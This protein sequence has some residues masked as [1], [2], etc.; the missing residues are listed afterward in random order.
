M[1]PRDPDETIIALF[2]NHAVQNEMASA[3]AGRP[4]FDDLEVVE[5]RFPG[6]RSVSVFPA[7]AVSHWATDFQTGY[8][9]Q[10]TYAERFSHQYRQFKQ[11]AA[12]TKSGTPLDYAPFLTE[13]RKAEL[14]AQNLYTIEQLA[15]IEGAELKNLGNGG[16]EMK[17]QAIAFIEESKVHAPDTQM[18]AELEALRARNAILEEDA[19][20]AKAAAVA[21]VGEFEAMSLDQL[22]QYIAT[23]SG[24]APLGSM[25]KKTLIRMAQECKPEKA[26]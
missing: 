10:V 5:I 8:Q 6:S 25:N 7:T 2:K 15:A 14:R 24:Q 21:E 12:Q 4:I 1:A 17:N 16:R 18:K 9:R 11:H 22:R 23:H 19:E 26:A 3:K 20:R 13:G